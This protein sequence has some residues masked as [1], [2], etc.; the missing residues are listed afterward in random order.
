MTFLEIE[1]SVI[2]INPHTT[3]KFYEM[4]TYFLEF[5]YTHTRVCSRILYFLKRNNQQ[6]TGKKRKL[7]VYMCVPGCILYIHTEWSHGTGK[8]PSCGVRPGFYAR[9]VFRV[10]VLLLPG[11]QT[12]L[13]SGSFSSSSSSFA[14]SLENVWLGSH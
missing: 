9:W 1:G 5:L 12:S 10:G 13:H 6:K 4:C 8:K 7:C 2:E 14:L 3:W 11:N